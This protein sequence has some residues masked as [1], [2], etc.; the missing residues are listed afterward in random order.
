CK[1]N[2]VIVDKTGTLTEGKVSLSSVTTFGQWQ[3]SQVLAIASALEAHANH[4]IAVAFRPHIDDS[5][6]ADAVEN[7]IGSGLTGTVNN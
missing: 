1:I 4:P 6:T 2:H 3:E 5:I 7:H